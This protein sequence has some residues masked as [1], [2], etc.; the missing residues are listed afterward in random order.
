MLPGEFERI[1][2]F[3]HPF[4]KLS[5]D[6]LYAILA[7][8]SEVFLVE[9]NCVYQDVDS[10]D[11]S[12]IHLLGSENKKLVAY[13]RL[14]LPAIKNNPIIFGR[15]VTAKIM[16]KNGHGKKLIQEMLNYCKANFPDTTIQSSAQLYLKKFYEG[17]GFQTIG[18]AYDE[19]GIPHIMMQMQR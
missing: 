2:F 16:R 18:D 10:K 7:L 9:Q 4:H 3:W 1:P 6:Q 15:V 19:D 13:L 8:R 14:F 17:F 11:I 5:V 12:A